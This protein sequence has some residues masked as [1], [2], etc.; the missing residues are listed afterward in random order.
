MNQIYRTLFILAAVSLVLLLLVGLANWLPAQAGP[1]QGGN[2]LIVAAAATPTATATRVP[3]LPYLVVSPPDS[4]LAIG[5]MFTVEVR[6][7]NVSNLYGADVRLQFDPSVVAVVDAS[8]N[9]GTQIYPGPFPDVVSQGFV[10]ANSADNVT[11]EIHYAATLLRP[12]APASGSGVLAQIVFRGL[13]SGASPIR[14]VNAQLSDPEG[15]QIQ[16]GTADGML[17]VRQPGT[18]TPTATSTATPTPIATHTRTP[19]PT[20]VACREL[21]ANG[22]FESNAAWYHP[23][24]PRR[25][26]Y[27]TSAAHQGV[28][29]MRHG[30]RPPT[31]D[32]YSYS[33]AYQSVVIPS[34]ATSAG[35]SFW[36]QPH[37]EDQTWTRSTVEMDAVLDTLGARLRG[38]LLPQGNPPPPANDYQLALILDRRYN[39]LQRIVYSNRNDGTWI[40]QTAD[41][42]AYRGR[43]INLYFD[44]INNGR[45]GRTWMFVDDV[46]LQVCTGGTTATTSLQGQVTL[47]GRQDH[48]QTA[49]AI[50]E[51]NW[52]TTTDRLGMFGCELGPDDPPAL[53]VSA[54]HDGYLTAQTQGE[55]TGQDGVL[56]PPATLDGG[57]ANND[58]VVNLLDLVIVGGSYGTSPPADP[59]ADINGDNVVNLL[60][61]VMVG[62]NY[63][64][65]GPTA[66]RWTE[67]ATRGSG[68]A[69]RV[70]VVPAGASRSAQAEDVPNLRPPQRGRLVRVALRVEDAHD[71]YAADVRYKFDPT[72]F[73][74]VD[75]DPA[76]PGVQ[77][78]VGSL[79]PEP[80]FVVVNKANNLTGEI[81]FAATLLRP[82]APVNGSGVLAWITLRAVEDKPEVMALDQM[83]EQVDATLAEALK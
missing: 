28:Q 59:R 49:I 40:S 33:S 41:L 77:L 13:A 4:E 34:N 30:V 21:I 3:G 79:L 39:I 38:E 61:L 5:G 25:A 8:P 73:Q 32:T 1:P 72:R 24:T 66:W 60:D 43:R 18:P 56:L 6:I 11:G 29:S 55:Q 46:S 82:A 27:T 63:G 74:V 19:T 2:H 48:S 54:V 62:S 26:D 23:I 64:L 37:T 22:G 9:S 71:L 14:F 15:V 7:E 45:N 31:S 36:Y 47:Q 81:R 57:D 10:A 52:C 69:G 44:V 76:R 58:N 16:V 35:L 17:H 65:Q 70:N 78:T 51:Q 67:G 12:A 50:D 80:R 20:A 42:M 83:L 68:M 75:A 53:S